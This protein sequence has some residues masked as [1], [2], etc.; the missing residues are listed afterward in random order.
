LLG[1]EL[2]AAA[3]LAALLRLLSG[4]GWGAELRSILMPVSPGSVPR[5]E[6]LP[7]NVSLAIQVS[8]AD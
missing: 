5:L 1:E 3:S 4:N 8:T 2:P 6:F 7:L